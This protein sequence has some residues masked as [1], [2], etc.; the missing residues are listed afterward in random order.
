MAVGFR[1]ALD[2]LTSPKSALLECARPKKLS[3]YARVRSI[4]LPVRL[5]PLVAALHDSA[6]A[7]LRWADEPAQT[8]P[9]WVADGADRA[10]QVLAGLS[11]MLHHPQARDALRRPWTEQLLDD[12]L[13]LADFHGCFRDSLVALRQL[14]NETHSALRRRDGVRLAAALRA[15]RRAAR[16]L[17][18]LASSARDLCHRAAPDDDVDEI[19][20]ADAFAAATAA[21][22]AA[23][24]AIF[25]GLS[26]ASAESAASAAPSPRT[27][28]PYSPARAPASPMWLV[29]DLL[30]RRRTVSFSFE[31]YCNEEEEERKAAMGRVR[32]LEECVAAAEG[33]GEQ[34][35]RA[36]VNARVSLL[37]LLTPTF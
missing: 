24:A 3:S 18:R 13:L 2:A 25:S 5:H 12:L 11:A 20:L 26:S 10:G 17:S 36:L 16:E 34:V 37:N 32:G 30:R 28:T 1:R 19:T 6:R 33:S 29:T 21:V 9:A 15:Q 22:A 31:E 7:L 23:S 14:L 4:S 27:P 8:G 35:Y